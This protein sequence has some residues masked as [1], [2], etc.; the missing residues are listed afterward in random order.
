MNKKWIIL[1]VLAVVIL[2]GAAYGV[3][4]QYA[5]KQ[6]REKEREAE[7]L[8]EQAK[9]EEAKRRAE[10]ENEKKRREEELQAMEEAVSPGALAQ[11][12][13]QFVLKLEDG[14]VTV[15]C[16]DL[17]TVYE[18]TSIEEA[19]L[20]ED[21]LQEIRQGKSIEGEQELYGFLENYTS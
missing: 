20:P 5:Q 14:Y 11:Q 2:S 8:R 7:L 3:S 15:Y 13:R 19:D 18:Y 16:E 6:Y 10:E 12:E 17:E 21:L 1:G 4:Y 9:K